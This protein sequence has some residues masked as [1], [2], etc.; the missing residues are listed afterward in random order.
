MRKSNHF[1]I[2]VAVILLFLLRVPAPAQGNDPALKIWFNKPASSW[3]EALPVGNGSL[4]AMVFGGTARE[5]LQLNE[6]S[7][8]TGAPRWD[9][10]PEAR[11]NLPAVRQLLLEGNNRCLA[12]HRTPWS[13]G[14]R[15]VAYGNSMELPEH[16][17]PLPVRRRY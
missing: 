16:L 8:W 7:V 9:A 10:N 17:G 6:E 5:R 2:C 14:L 1:K 15:N 4:G 12:L 11:R 3:N 13:C